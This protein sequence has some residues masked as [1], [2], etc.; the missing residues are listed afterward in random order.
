MKTFPY[1]ALGGTEGE[2]LLVVPA[3]VGIKTGNLHHGDQIPL[4]SL[5][6]SKASPYTRK[7]EKINPYQLQRRAN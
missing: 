6:V 7:K 5:L 4:A 3:V 1:Y 2:V